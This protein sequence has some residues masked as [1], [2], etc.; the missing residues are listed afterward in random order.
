MLAEVNQLVRQV[1]MLGAFVGPSVLSSPALPQATYR[2][3]PFDEANLKPSFLAFRTELITAVARRDIDFVVEQAT[4]DIFLSFGSVAGRTE[5][6]SML[7]S[8]GDAY[9]NELE[10]VLRLGGAFASA[11]VFEAPYTWAA[12]LPD[13]LDPFFAGFIIGEE[14]VLRD[15]P[16][17]LGAVLALLDYEVVTLLGGGEG[18]YEAVRTAAGVDGYVHHD[19]V[20]SPIDYRAIFERRDGRWLIAVFI[21]GD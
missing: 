5:F 3:E 13:D 9:W 12:D 17:R 11:S 21:A 19:Y 20:R 16:N 14:V 4:E 8:G 10:E 6:R 2:V 15:R 18:D 1:L 7:T